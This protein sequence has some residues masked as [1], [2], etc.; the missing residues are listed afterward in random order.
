MYVVTHKDCIWYAGARVIYTRVPTRGASLHM[1]S[2]SKIYVNDMLSGSPDQLYC[3]DLRGQ[4]EEVC[5]A[6]LIVA[7]VM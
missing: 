6:K 7:P 2:A 1:A 4:T 5:V 3:T